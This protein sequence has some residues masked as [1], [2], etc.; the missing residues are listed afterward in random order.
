M[1][2]LLLAALGVMACNQAPPAPCELPKQVVVEYERGYEP[3]DPALSSCRAGKH[4]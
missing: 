4:P 1:R 2:W 3:H